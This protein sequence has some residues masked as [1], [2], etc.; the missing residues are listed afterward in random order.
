MSAVNR[1]LIMHALIPALKKMKDY[2]QPRLRGGRETGQQRGSRSCNVFTSKLS[3][4][5]QNI[6]FSPQI[7][8]DEQSQLGL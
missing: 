8:P 6:D 5:A 3:F 2:A 7:F 4:V 1:N